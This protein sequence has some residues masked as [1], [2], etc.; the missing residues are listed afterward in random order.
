MSW[1]IGFCC[2]CWNLKTNNLIYPY[3]FLEPLI[4]IAEPFYSLFNSL[5]LVLCYVFKNDVLQIKLKMRSND[6]AYELNKLC[7]DEQVIEKVLVRSLE[8][9]IRN[10]K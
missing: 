8:E 6:F 7:F 9:D 3:V 5:I 4:I 10:L 2:F 1:L